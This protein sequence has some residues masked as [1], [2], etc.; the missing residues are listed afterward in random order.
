MVVL[1]PGVAL[2]Q[3]DAGTPAASSLSRQHE[4]LFF[5]SAKRTVDSGLDTPVFDSHDFT[6]TADIFYSRGADRLRMLAEYLITDDEH[7][8][9]RFQVGW[10]LSETTRIWFGRRHWAAGG[11][12]R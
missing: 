6:P 4:L 7:D 1:E 10:Q 5:V 3:H 9:E 2:A 8:L 12:G 11:R